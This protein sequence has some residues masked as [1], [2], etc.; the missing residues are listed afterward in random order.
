MDILERLLAESTKRYSIDEYLKFENI[1]IEKH[2]YYQGVIY[3]REELTVVSDDEIQK[4]L[5]TGDFDRTKY[6]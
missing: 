4:V 5:L 6:F 2:E 1:S 3:N